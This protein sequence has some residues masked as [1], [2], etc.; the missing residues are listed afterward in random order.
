M[1][2]PSA[3]NELL[4]SPVEGGYVVYDIDRNQFHELN[5][6]A[7]LLLELCDGSRSIDEVVEAAAG[8]LPEGSEA[9][10]RDWVDQAS[11]VVGVRI[12]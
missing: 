11:E 7:A 10:T 12:G 1:K 2:F 3:R 5:A 4:I 6:A 9:A 8:V